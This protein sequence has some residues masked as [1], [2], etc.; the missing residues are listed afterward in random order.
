MVVGDG[1]VGEFLNAGCGVVE[2]GAGSRHGGRAGW[3]GRVGEQA[4]GLSTVRWLTAGCARPRDS[5]RPPRRPVDLINEPRSSR[6]LRSPSHRIKQEDHHYY[7]PVRLRVP[8]RYSPPHVSDARGTP[9][10]PPLVSGIGL[11]R[12]TPSHVP[13]ESSRSRSRHLCTGH[14]PA[15]TRAPPDLSRVELKDPVS[16]S[17][18]YLTTLPRKTPHEAFDA[19]PS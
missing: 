13:H 15:N 4:A 8:R 17:L 14:R 9:L 11:Y 16:M 2:G 18:S 1:E 3:T 10:A 7:E 19:T 6:P 12:D 5:S